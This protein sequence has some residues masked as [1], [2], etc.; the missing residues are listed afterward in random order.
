MFDFDT[1]PKLF[2]ECRQYLVLQKEYTK[3]EMTE[4]LSKLL[5]AVLLVV[6]AGVLGIGV[7]FYLSL[8]LAF[9]LIPLVESMAA[10]LAIIAGI[11]LIVGV[12]VI[13]LR[14]RLIVRPTMRFI[15]GLILR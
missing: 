2:E 9:L 6:V 1:I 12:V 10:S 15:A 4:R 14:K 11:Y 13:A 3:L 5:S 7:L 8:A